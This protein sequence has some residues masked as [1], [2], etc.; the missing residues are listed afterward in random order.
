MKNAARWREAAGS[1]STDWR[2]PAPSSSPACRAA[3]S[4]LLNKFGKTESEGGGFRCVISDALT[5]GI[6]VVIGVPRRN[7]A[8]WRD[9]ARRLLHRSRFF[10]PLIGVFFALQQSQAVAAF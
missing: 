9:Y 6:P 7:L 5:L 8:A 3:I 10:R 2:G 4:I 1:I